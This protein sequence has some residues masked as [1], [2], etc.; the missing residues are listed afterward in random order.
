MLEYSDVSCFTV[1]FWVEVDSVQKGTQP[2]GDS[3][4]Q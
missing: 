2:S 4:Y 3:A 1:S